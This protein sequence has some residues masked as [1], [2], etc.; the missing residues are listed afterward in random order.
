MQWTLNLIRHEKKGW[1][2]FCLGT[3]NPLIEKELDLRLQIRLLGSERILHH[4]NL[5][6]LRV[7][8][9]REWSLSLASEKTIGEER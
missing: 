6:L 1:K 2:G 9:E 3:K 7:G 4:L 8:K 5:S